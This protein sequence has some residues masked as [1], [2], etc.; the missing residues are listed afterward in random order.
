M[1]TLIINNI[2][3]LSQLILNVVF[4]RTFYEERQDTDA[5]S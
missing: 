1:P 4:K 5:T 2:N 3:S